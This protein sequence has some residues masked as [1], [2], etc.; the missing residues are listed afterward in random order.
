L[1]R[2]Y[3]FDFLCNV[4]LYA[5]RFPGVV[6]AL[7]FTS[8]DVYIITTKQ[9]RFCKLLLHKYGITSVPED[10]IFGY[11]SGSKISV[12]KKL[13]AIPENAGRDV[14]F[15]EDRY[16]TLEAVSLS[17]L[18]QPLQLYL[19]TWGYNTEKTRKTAE[20]H[21]FISLIDLNTFVSKFQ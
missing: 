9:T 16:E 10:R 13:L 2:T 18:G 12:L 7:N 21:P 20:M 17:M 1:R 4:A 15:V 14:C 3:P 8:A 11:G 6:D 5:F 19:A